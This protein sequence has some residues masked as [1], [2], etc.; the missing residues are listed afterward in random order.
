VGQE[1]LTSQGKPLLWPGSVLLG[2]YVIEQC[3]YISASKSIYTCYDNNAGKRRITLKLLE[4]PENDQSCS[5]LCSEIRRIFRMQSDNVLKLYDCAR[6]KN[7]LLLFTELE[8]HELDEEESQETRYPEISLLQAEF[9]KVEEED[10]SSVDAAT[11][12]IS[13]SL[14]AQLSLMITNLLASLAMLIGSEEL[15]E[16]ISGVRGINLPD[17]G[18]PAQEIDAIAG[19]SLRRLLLLFSALS[20]VAAIFVLVIAPPPQLVDWWND[21][22]GVF[23]SK[24]MKEK[25]GY[26]FYAPKESTANIITSP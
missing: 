23:K 11:A 10:S 9:L 12:Q 18:G 26:K 20:F 21:V 4:L 19:P 17:S 25:E 1:L 7:R 2:K 24:E 3:I 8:E 16:K 6:D 5:N 15:V 22:S 14:S 13:L